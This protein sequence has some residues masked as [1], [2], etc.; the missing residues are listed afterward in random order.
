MTKRRILITGPS[1]ENVS[2]IST[3]LKTILTNNSEQHR[4][5]HF[6]TG[7][8]DGTAKRLKWLFNQF[9]LAPAF[10]LTAIRSR[11]EI[12]HFNTD[13]TLNSIVRDSILV[14]IARILLRKKMIVHCHG[15]YYLLN[16]PGKGT[17][18]F[19]VIYFMFRSADHIIV[20]TK[21]EQDK[22]I[23][24]YAIKSTVLANTVP[25]AVKGI[26]AFR[27]K[28]N[29]LY[30]GRIHKSKGLSTIASAFSLLKEQ[31]NAFRFN[32]YGN[33]PELD[34]FLHELA[35]QDGLD[36]CYRGVVSGKD[37]ITVLQQ[38]DIFLLPSL[39]GEGMPIALLESM[40]YGCVP[41]VSDDPSFI[42]VI[43]HRVNGLISQKG[44][45]ENLAEILKEALNAP[46]MLKD[47]SLRAGDT[48]ETRYNLHSYLEKLNTIYKIINQHETHQLL[49]NRTQSYNV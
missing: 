9:L 13:L 30:L 22:L 16:P 33:G 35:K 15:G 40:S 3:L 11:A 18:L 19:K 7:K 39:Y 37:K 43:E 2:G 32:I 46:S 31:Y 28:L 27:N 10:M 38:A 24:T 4:Y 44:N 12:I 48:I 36:Y 34:G 45:P 49:G 17:I 20:L 47:M 41:V 26:K 21:F 42:E 14:F 5:L 23:D 8:K 6:E 29:I 25:P 1:T